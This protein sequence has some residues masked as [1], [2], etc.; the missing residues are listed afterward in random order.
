MAYPNRHA[1]RY[2]SDLS[3]DS[4]ALYEEGFE[5]LL[6]Y[7]DANSPL[8]ERLGYSVSLK[9]DPIRFGQKPIMHFHASAFSDL[10]LL[11]E[12]GLYKLNNVYWGMFGVNGPLPLHLTEYAIERKYRHQDQTLAAFCDIFH[13]RFISLFYRAWA[14]S[15]PAVSHD[16]PDKDT[17]AKR[18]SSLSGADVQQQCYLAGLLSHKNKSADVLAQL[19]SQHLHQ[20]VSISQF[21]GKWYSLPEAHK[22]KLGCANSQLGMDCLIGDST[23][24][25]GFSYSVLIGPLKYQDYLCF[26]QNP[27]IFKQI[28]KLAVRHTGSEFNLSIKLLLHANV[29]QTARLGAS[30]SDPQSNNKQ[31]T[32]SRLG[33]NAWLAGPL[34]GN[35]QP[36]QQ[37]NPP[38]VAYEYACD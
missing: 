15:Q 14:E 21:E 10:R 34:E 26:I 28:Q 16:R 1:Q 4:K 2:L 37:V 38:V 7:V 31:T 35:L 33:T 25:R 20:R 13:H 36:H 19:L 6:R 30:G 32:P 8:Y 9:Q 22:N 12:I 29:F 27:D 23:F 11:K 18:I 5:S 17:F 24:E 3:K